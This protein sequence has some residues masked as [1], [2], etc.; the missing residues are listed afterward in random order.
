MEEDTNTTKDTTPDITHMERLLMVL[1]LTEA[2]M[3]TATEATMATV[4]TVAIAH[5]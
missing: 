1:V 5:T 4:G 2:M 3:A